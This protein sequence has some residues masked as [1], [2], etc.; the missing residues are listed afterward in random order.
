MAARIKALCNPK[1][2]IWARDTAGFSRAEVTAKLGSEEIRIATWEDEDGG[3]APSIPQLRKL[4]DLY[5]RPLAVFYLPN[6]PAGFQV[7]RDLRRLPGTGLRRL[8]PELVLEWRRATERRELAI[9]LLTDIGEEPQ[10]FTLQA[11]RSENPEIVGQRIRSRY[12]CITA[13]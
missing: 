4:A 7:I 5:K 11:E 8:P 3:D 2:L 1:V 10:A 6:V 12:R 9:E 13:T